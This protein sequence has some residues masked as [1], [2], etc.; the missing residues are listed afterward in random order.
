[1]TADELNA[2]ARRE[3][4]D[5]LKVAEAKLPVLADR[6]HADEQLVTLAVGHCGLLSPGRA[7]L[8]AATDR[9]RVVAALKKVRPALE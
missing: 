5:A 3:L 4:G 2:F 1:M 7:C 6:L 9:R 8:V